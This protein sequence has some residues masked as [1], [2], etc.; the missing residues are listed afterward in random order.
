[1]AANKIIVMTIS[2]RRCYSVTLQDHFSGFFLDKC[3]SP[4][5]KRST[6]DSI[7]AT[8]YSADLQSP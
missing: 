7:N 3:K 8:Q 1:M 6:V 5:E 4:L 2:N